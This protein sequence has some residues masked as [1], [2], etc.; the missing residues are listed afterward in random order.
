MGKFANK[1]MPLALVWGLVVHLCAFLP[2]LTQAQT[3][4]PNQDAMSRGNSAEGQAGYGEAFKSQVQTSYSGQNQKEY[5]GDNLTNG[6]SGGSAASGLSGQLMATSIGLIAGGV[7]LNASSTC[8]CAGLPMIASGVYFGLGSQGASNASNSMGGMAD[9]SGFNRGNLDTI[10][11]NALVNNRNQVITTGG[12]IDSN[13]KSDSTIK[14]G[15]AQSSGGSSTFKATAR[16]EITIDSA[17]LRS[18]KI[19]EA[20][21]KIEK[22]YGIDREDMA[23]AIARG[24][25]IAK[26]LESKGALHGKSATEFRAD[27]SKEQPDKDA[28]RSSFE[29]G[30]YDEYKELAKNDNSG[31]S[32]EFGPGGGTLDNAAASKDG[33][34]AAAGQQPTEQQK[35]A[36]EVLAEIF[37]KKGEGNAKATDALGDKQL[38]NPNDPELR[39]LASRTDIVLS[40]DYVTGGTYSESSLFQR[41]RARYRLATPAMLSTEYFMEARFG[42]KPQ[43][44]E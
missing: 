19:G 38:R 6:S 25:D 28:L 3:T 17:A 36:Q 21:D 24:E 41:V 35:S 31:S 40:D 43:R 44:K 27:L 18:G 15:G 23:N 22:A 2:S 42:K 1:S 33:K 26:Y 14:G 5:Q 10:D 16:T 12:V 13:L 34:R 20:F 30:E 9:L 8:H 4:N 37:G 32:T 7:A 29:K 39:A 11:T